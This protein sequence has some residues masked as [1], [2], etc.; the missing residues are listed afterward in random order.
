MAQTGDTEAIDQLEQYRRLSEAAFQVSP[1]PQVIVD[2]KGNLVLANGQA[3]SLFHLAAE[4]LDR[5]LRD[6]EFSYRPVDLRSLIDKVYVDRLPVAVKEVKRSLPGGEFQYLDVQV[7]PLKENGHQPIGVSI[8]FQDVTE[9]KKIIEEYHRSRQELDTAYEEL[10]STNE[11]LETTNEE[12]QSTVEELQTTNEELQSTNEEME[13]MNE[14]LQST[15]EELETTNSELQQVTTEH[16]RLNTFLHS[17]LTSIRLGVVV[18][19][20][21]LKVQLWNNQAKELWGLLPDE[22][23][24][25]PFLKLDIGLPVKKL[26]EPLQTF[27][28]GP[29]NN[30]EILLKAVNRKGQ[31]IECIIRIAP[32]IGPKKERQ[33]LVLLMEEK[34]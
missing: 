12:L 3:R 23:V 11:E 34:K 10:Q 15:N 28:Q 27:L 24:G 33:G 25:R 21:D 26:K 30:L 5:P 17:I 6:L 31:A 32:I 16:N 18:L 2:K 20:K 29:K 22:V 13:T 14:E 9:H 8:I 19:N 4:D 1:D 7:I